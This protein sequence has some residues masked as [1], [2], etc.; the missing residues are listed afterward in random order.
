[1]LGLLLKDAG[2][3]FRDNMLNAE[4]SIFLSGCPWF[5]HVSVPINA[6]AE[7]RS[8]FT[9]LC[10]SSC[11]LLRSLLRRATFHTNNEFVAH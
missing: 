7:L 4:L 8:I 6:S 1:M 5:D 10:D 3:Y 2:H 9:I 11:T